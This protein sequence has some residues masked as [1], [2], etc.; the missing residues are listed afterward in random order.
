VCA[1]FHSCNGRLAQAC[2][3]PQNTQAIQNKYVDTLRQA[4]THC[5][6]AKPQPKHVSR[7][8]Q[9]PKQTTMMMMMMFPASCA[10]GDGG[11]RRAFAFRV[12]RGRGC[13]KSG[14][15]ALLH[16]R[17]DSPTQTHTSTFLG[18][19]NRFTRPIEMRGATSG[20]MSC[21]HLPDA[22]HCGTSSNQLLNCGVDRVEAEAEASVWRATISTGSTSRWPGSR[23]HKTGSYLCLCCRILHARTCPH[24]DWFVD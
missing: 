20:R 21:I 19:I 15:P 17:A 7:P 1:G 2:A 6:L 5:V 4:H 24:H 23:T 11:A 12:G 18:T 14:G 10:G 16:S 22:P 8:P 3:S 13:G 9:A